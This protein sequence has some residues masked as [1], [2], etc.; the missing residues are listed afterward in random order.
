MDGLRPRNREI[1]IGFT[2]A[3]VMDANSPPFFLISL[4]F[5]LFLV[6]FN[7]VLLGYCDF[8]DNLSVDFD[9]SQSF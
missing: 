8:I 1:F 6:K 7:W 3:E 5:D 9:V 4:K 2:K